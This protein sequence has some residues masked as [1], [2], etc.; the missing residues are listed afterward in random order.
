MFL[1]AQPCVRRAK[2]AFLGGSRPTTFPAGSN[3]I[4]HGEVA[5]APV[6][7]RG[8]GSAP[9]DEK[10][11]RRHWSWRAPFIVFS[12]VITLILLYSENYGDA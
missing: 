11:T 7:E 2:A 1:G 9:P 8:D 5:E 6:W 3:R 12:S 10:D 4:G